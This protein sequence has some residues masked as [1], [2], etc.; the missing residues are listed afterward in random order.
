[1]TTVG[2]SL[3]GLSIAVLTLP[4][5]RSLVW[6]LLVGHLYVF[7]A[8]LPDFPLPGW[9]HDSYQVSH[10]I[11][12]TALL[13]SMMA[14]LL[15]LPKFNARVGATVLFAWTVA[16]FSHMLLDSMYSHGQGIG[17]FWPFSDAHLALPVSWFDTLQWPPRTAHNIRVFEIELL[18][19]GAA[20]AWCIGLR[21]LWP[22]TRKRSR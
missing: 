11:F 19:F 7:F 17:I 12:L 13:A 10:S 9:G 14:L 1:M 22:R 6:Y 21:W 2:H 5:G 15:L 20:L 3:T 8:N 18:T 4:R 16:W